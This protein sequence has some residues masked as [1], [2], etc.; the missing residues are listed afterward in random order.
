MCPMDY[1]GQYVLGIRGTSNQKADKGTIVH[2]V[3]ELLAVAKKAKQDGIDHIDDEI[4]G[5]I[6]LKDIRLTP[7]TQEVFNYYAKAFA[8]HVWDD[9]DLEDCREWII[10][11][12]QYNGGMFDPRKREI[13]QPE[14]HFDITIDRPWAHYDYDL[15]GR[16]FNGQLALKGTIDL[17]TKVDD[18]CYEV[19]DWKTGKRL[20]WATGEEK[21]LEKLYED[22]QLRIYH[23]ALS[24]VYPQIEQVL[25]TIFFIN[26]GGA[27]TV[28]F[29]K[30]DLP[31]TEDMIR[32]KFELIKQT[33]I[34]RLNKSWKCGKLCHFGKNT[35]EGT[36]K[37]ALKEFRAGQTT[38]KG[39]IMTMCEQHLYELE[40]HGLDKTTQKYMKP[41]FSP[42]DYK[43]PGSIE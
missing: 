41:G 30:D 17:I 9:K 19:V 2:K 42:I 29:T 35:Y 40:T 16:R 39:S 28:C 27:Y 10:K 14:L 11:A 43:A 38:P 4:V 24:Q 5:K 22:P 8:H 15:N 21:T 20:N 25:V 26:D 18:S 34:P 1:F 23:Y 32:R 31:K 6:A 33:T 36:D 3:L 37:E 12:L 7:L 13:V